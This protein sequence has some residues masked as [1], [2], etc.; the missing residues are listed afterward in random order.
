MIVLCLVLVLISGILHALWYWNKTLQ[1]WGDFFICTQNSLLCMLDI[2]NMLQHF[3]CV[4]FLLMWDV[5]NLCI[6]KFLLLR[7]LHRNLISL[8][9]SVRI[10]FL[11]VFSIENMSMICLF[12]LWKLMKHRDNKSVLISWWVWLQCMTWFTHVHYFLW[13]FVWYCNMVQNY[14]HV[15]NFLLIS[16]IQVDLNLVKQTGNVSIVV[17]FVY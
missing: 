3:K 2:F 5:I 15:C 8:N 13:L 1:Y 10:I 17:T 12:Q 9:S 11:A 6:L 14:C 4:C 16:Y 7:D